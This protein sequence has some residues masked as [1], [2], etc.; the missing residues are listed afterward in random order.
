MKPE[1]DKIANVEN[2]LGLPEDNGIKGWKEVLL[3][4]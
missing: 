1:N 2:R 4:L 3:W